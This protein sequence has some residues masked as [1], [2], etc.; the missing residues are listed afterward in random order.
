ML[1]SPVQDKQHCLQLES[2][3]NNAVGNLQHM[4]PIAVHYK[5]TVVGVY[6]YNAMLLFGTSNDSIACNAA[7]EAL[8]LCQICSPAPAADPISGH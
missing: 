4:S 5:C 8:Y 1:G 3:G 7:S 6:S 2:T